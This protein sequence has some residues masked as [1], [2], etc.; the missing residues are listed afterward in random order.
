MRV[1]GLT[2]GIASGKS[3]VSRL[4]RAAGIP[5]VDADA[6]VHRLQARGEAAWRAIWAHFGW[7]V[8]QPDGELDR[9]RLGRWVFQDPTARQALGRLVHPAVREALRA[10][11]EE[12]ERRGVPLMVWDVPLLIEGGLFREVDEVWVVY[13]AREQQV[14]RLMA[15]NGLTEE[16]AVR[17]VASQMP[18]DEKL[19][20]AHVVLDNRGTPEDLER[21]VREV[22]ASR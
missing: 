16:E 19:R 8:L 9:V 2:G 10:A 21:Q 13:A 22:L 11:R 20:Y 4:L 7:A 17:R 6:L 14:A 15:R 3:T 1:I 5:V 12:L 18:L